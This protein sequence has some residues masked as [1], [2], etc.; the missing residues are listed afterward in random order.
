MPK[1][2]DPFKS[3]HKM[4]VPTDGRENIRRPKPEGLKEGLVELKASQVSEMSNAASSVEKETCLGAHTS[5]SC[6]KR[7][8]FPRNPLQK[9][10]K[11][12]STVP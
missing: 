1:L 3:K 11:A 8:G 12:L 7:T 6:H 2:K 5:N 10:D 4:F 9:I